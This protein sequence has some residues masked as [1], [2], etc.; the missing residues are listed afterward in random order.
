MTNV[1]DLAVYVLVRNDLPSMNPGKAMS[2]VHHLG[3][4]LMAKCGTYGLC[5][6]YV[7][8][9][10]SQGADHFN[11]TIVLAADLD[12]IGQVL[13]NAYLMP[14]HEVITST[15]VDPSYPFLVENEEIAGLIPETEVLQKVKVL[16]DGRVLMTRSVLTCAGVLG[17][18]NNPNFRALFDGLDLHP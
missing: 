16:P 7:Q 10:I 6:D 18:R 9:G 8:H 3:V 1:P 4:Q 14:D 5:Q 11:T 2:Q 12:Q 17:D 15:V 13:N